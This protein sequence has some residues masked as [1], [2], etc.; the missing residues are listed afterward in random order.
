V[1]RFDPWKDPLGV[2]DAF[3]RAREEVPGIQLIMVGSLA[4]DDPE[5]WHYLE[6]TEEHRD[7]DPDVHILTN[8]QNVGSHAVNAFQRASTVVVQKSLRE[9]FGLT[10]SEAMWKQRPVIVGG[11]GGLRLQVDDGESGFLVDSVDACAGRLVELLGDEDRRARMG[12]AAKERVR[13]AFL[14]TREV[15][16]HVRLLADLEA[17]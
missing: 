10:C 1:S 16:D 12:K 17:G 3:R 6:L 2:I 9:G 5:G 8:L 7:E 4:H 15:E 14:S 13:Q 11:V